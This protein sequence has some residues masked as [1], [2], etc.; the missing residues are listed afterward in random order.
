MDAGCEIKKTSQLLYIHRNTIPYRLNKIRS[1]T[2]LHPSSLTSS[3]LL[4]I[5][6]ACHRLAQ[7]MEEG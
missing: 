4:N 7:S 5:T 1:I 6:A 2:G 3:W